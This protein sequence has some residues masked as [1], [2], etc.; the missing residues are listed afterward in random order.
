MNRWLA[1]NERNFFAFAALAVL[2]LLV[3]GFSR[4]FYFLPLFEGAPYY[5]AL[6]PIFYI[7]GLVFTSWF[8]LL[9]SQIALVRVRNV[10]LHRTLGLAGVALATLIVVFGTIITLVAANR[11]GGFIEIPLPPQVFAI[12]PLGGMAFFAVFV[13]LG[14][15]NRHDPS[16]HKRF[17]FLASAVL[18][19]AAVARIP[20]MF[21][22]DLPFFEAYVVT[23]LVAL[24]AAWDLI[25]MRRLHKVT[26]WAGLALVVFLFVRVPLGMT[27]AWQAFALWLMRL[28][29]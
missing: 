5:A 4:S 18:L 12:V 28:A 27:D 8:V 1:L 25:S 21:R 7:H 10:N 3:F 13:A 2:A 16:S 24:L 29:A 9:A 23:A 26:L 19:E 17:M 11:P 14:Y 6:E 20:L 15:F 22:L